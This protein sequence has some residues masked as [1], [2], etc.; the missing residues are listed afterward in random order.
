M[1]VIAY[2]TKNQALLSYDDIKNMALSNPDGMGWMANI[3]GV[4]HYKKGY[5]NVD[6]FYNDYVTLR[7]NKKLVDIALHFRIGTGSAID[8]ANCHPFPI[9]RVEK[10]IRRAKGTCDVAIM[11][12]GIIGNSTKQYSDTAIYTMTNLRDYYDRD[13]RFFLHLNKRQKALFENEIHGCRFVFMSKDGT[14]LFGIGWSDYDGKA[15]VSNRHWIPMPISYYRGIYNYDDTY[16]TDNDIYDWD[17]FD[18]WYADRAKRF[19][20]KK[21]DSRYKSYIDYLEEGVI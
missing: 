12:N 17:S 5:F 15:Q 20:K 10:K 11:M 18:S 6:E 9:T 8:V 4:I 7:H 21:S 1:C 19:S 13:N 3:D 14:K 16:Y 2:Q